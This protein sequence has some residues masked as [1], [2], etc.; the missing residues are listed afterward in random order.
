M[1]ATLQDRQ[2]IS[3]LMT[4]WIYRDLADWEK[5]AGLFH[6]DGTIEVT[7]FEGLAKDF[8]EGLVKMGK[9][10]LHTKHL[11]GHPTIRFN[12]PK[13]IVETNAMIIAE[14]VVLN[15]G[16]V[17]HNRFYDL[18]E[19]REGAWRIVRRQ[20]IYDT[21]YFTFPLG[22]VEIDQKA[23]GKSPREYAAL[24]YL[25]EESGFP[26]RRAFATKGSELEKKMKEEGQA[27]LAH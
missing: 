11:V 5:L 3:D 27:W 10:D 14:N 25:L 22:I 7:W 24:A 6:P 15:L 13:A 4:G 9:S 20:S 18:V 26:V 16:C 12:G 2:D 23:V 17:A 21:G 19:K 8:I 1:Q